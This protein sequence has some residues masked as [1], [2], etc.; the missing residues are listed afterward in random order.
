MSLDGSMTKKDLNQLDCFTTS[1]EGTGV[2]V[3]V[4]GERK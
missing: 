2:R 3:F 4:D 1:F